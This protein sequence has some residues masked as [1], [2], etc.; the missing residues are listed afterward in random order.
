MTRSQFFPDL[1]WTL[2]AQFIRP[3]DQ[4]QAIKEF[5]QAIRAS[6]HA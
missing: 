5:L 6:N 1:D 2:F 4:P 3:Q